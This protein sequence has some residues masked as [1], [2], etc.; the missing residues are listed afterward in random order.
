MLELL[1]EAAG[2]VPEA[3]RG[4]VAAAPEQDA[5]VALDERLRAGN[6]VRLD[7]RAALLALGL[8]RLVPE[9]SGAE[10]GRSASRR[11]SPSGLR[12]PA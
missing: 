10:Q 2:N 1:D 5:A 8:A 11:G 12:Y 3:R 4:I 6:R 9:R 7:R